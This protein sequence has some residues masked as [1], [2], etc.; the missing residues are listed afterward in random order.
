MH[1]K[2]QPRGMGYLV[3]LS[4]KLH[5]INCI[6][7]CG[8][9]GNKVSAT[10]LAKSNEGHFGASN[11]FETDEGGRLVPSLMF[12][13][14][15]LSYFGTDA[16]YGSI[17]HGWIVQGS[18]DDTSPVTLPLLVNGE[19]G[20]G[21]ALLLCSGI[22][23][24]VG[25][26][27]PVS[28]VYMIRTGHSDNHI[29]AS[30]I[31]G[32]DCWEFGVTDEAKL[33]AKGILKS[34]YAVYHN[35]PERVEPDSLGAACT[36]HSQALN[37][38]KETEILN[39]IP[40]P[41]ATAVLLVLCS[42]SQGTEDRTIAAIYRVFINN[43]DISSHVIAG[44]KGNETTSD[45]HDLWSFSLKNNA[46]KA[47]GPEG[48]CR[49]AVLTNVQNPSKSKMNPKHGQLGCLA[50][51]RSEPIRGAVTITTDDLIGWVSSAC[52]IVVTRDMVPLLE[53]SADSLKQ[54]EGKFC[55]HHKWLP[56]DK[57][58]LAILRVHAVVPKGK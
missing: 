8:F 32:D 3:V 15:H 4:V 49:Y 42:T 29:Q 48:P 6:S 56:V 21:C 25:D 14:N 33:N 58:G 17:T 52:N 9:D 50:T 13:T 53:F 34:T 22:E 57:S 2:F 24:G 31:Q 43:G 7:R 51:G 55:F 28:A 12:G 39:A 1:V 18:D 23:T 19:N 11:C 46:L 45:T 20:A 37:G 5:I 54:K 44:S 36:E 16:R 35:R 47:V 27:K 30:L 38:T 40:D 26:A 10:S 41:R